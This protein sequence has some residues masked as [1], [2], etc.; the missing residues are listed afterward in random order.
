MKKLPTIYGFNK[1]SEA[2]LDLFAPSIFLGGCNLRCP[3]CMNSKLINCHLD[4]TVDIDV[5]RQYVLEDKSKMLM[6]SGGEPFCTPPDLL[7]NLLDEI[8]TWGCKIG[9]STNGTKVDE[10]KDFIHYFNYVAMDFKS[11]KHEVYDKIGEPSLVLNVL[12]CKSFLRLTAMNR[13]DFI[14]EIRTTLY[15]PFIDKKDIQQIAQIIGPSDTWILQQF[16]HAKNMLDKN[17]NDVEPY[18]EAQIKEFIE[19]AKEFTNNVYLRYV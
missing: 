1:A 11:S 19:I 18:T 17:C 10:L 14:Y 12:V 16:R 13:K 6:I 8:K 2:G 15:P 9:V 3:Y 5:V 7:T 4:K